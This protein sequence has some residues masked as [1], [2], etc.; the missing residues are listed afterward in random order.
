MA[1][2]NNSVHLSAGDEYQQ[3]WTNFSRRVNRSLDEVV[4]E[5]VLQEFSTPLSVPVPSFQENHQQTHDDFDDCA[6]D[7]YE[8]FE[9]HIADE[10]VEKADPPELLSEDLKDDVFFHEFMSDLSSSTQV[11]ANYKYPSISIMVFLLLHRS[12]ILSHN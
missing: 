9:E 11:N 3:G 2:V 5:D 1:Y 12:F 8:D 6:D 10:F 4:N 7:D